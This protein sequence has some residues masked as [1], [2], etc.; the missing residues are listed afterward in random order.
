MTAYRQDALTCA[1]HLRDHG[2]CKP[3][4]VRDATGV[5]K[6]ARIVYDNHYGW[7]E[8]EGP[9]AYAVS[10]KGVAALDEYRTVVEALAGD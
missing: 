7:F 8:R 5:A 6:A 9:G 1:L 2:T 4:Q 3:A 10:E